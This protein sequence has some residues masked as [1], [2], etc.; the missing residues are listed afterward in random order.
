MY[1]LPTFTT[2]PVQITA[3]DPNT[4]AM[5]SAN[6]EAPHFSVFIIV[7]VVKHPVFNIFY[8]KKQ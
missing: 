8:I 3:R 5:N 6:D 4:L 1:F 2:D 7:P